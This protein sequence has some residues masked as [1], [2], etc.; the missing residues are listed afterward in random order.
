[1]IR[2]LPRRKGYAYGE[3]VVLDRVNSKSNKGD[4]KIRGDENSDGKILEI[5]TLI[6]RRSLR[7]NE[8]SLEERD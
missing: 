3:E 7:E 8:N 5:G 6:V 2:E 4:E 1:M